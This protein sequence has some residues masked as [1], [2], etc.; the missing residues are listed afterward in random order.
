MS[1]AISNDFWLNNNLRVFLL[2]CDL[3]NFSKVASVLGVTQSS[4]SKS[5]AKL[6]NE[7]GFTLFLRDTR[8]LTLT[9][10]AKVLQHQLQSITGDI[11]QTFRL[12]QS[13]NFIKPELHLG[14]VE[15]LAANF[16]PLITKTELSNFSKLFFLSSTSNVLLQRLLEKKLDI[17][18]VSDPFP[19]MNFLSR[20]LLYEE[21]SILLIPRSMSE[22]R[23]EPWSWAAL[24]RCG[25]PMISYWQESGGGKLNEYFFRTNKLEF[26]ERLVVD[27]NAMMLSLIAAG[28]GWTIGRPSTLLQCAGFKDQIRF[29]KAPEPNFSRRIYLIARKEENEKTLDHLT[30]ICRQITAT[31]LIPSM[32]KLTPWLQGQI[33]LLKESE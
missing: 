14:I 2:L 30:E 6:E 21:P 23:S 28:M 24:S 16:A 29:S 18:I 19:S 10:E 4:V 12:L 7:L 13:E 33:R 1:E 27:T 9:I 25:L 20:R 26:P 22:R 11:A 15:S 32:L 5:I 8:P 17:I 31:D 3:R